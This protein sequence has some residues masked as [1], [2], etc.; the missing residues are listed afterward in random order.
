MGEVIDLAA[1]RP[2]GDI[3]D[4]DAAWQLVQSIAPAPGLGGDNAKLLLAAFLVR[5]DEAGELHASREE[6]CAHAGYGFAGLD[7]ALGKLRRHGWI[8]G[9]APSGRYRLTPSLLKRWQ[10]V[11]PGRRPAAS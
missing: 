11:R 8:A 1:R 10:A 4:A 6:L 7:R 3:S 2:T 5:A 9:D